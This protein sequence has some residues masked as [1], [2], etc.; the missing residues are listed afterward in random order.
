MLEPCLNEALT[1]AA[2]HAKPQKVSVTI[3]A[4]ANL[5]R[6]CVEN[7]GFIKAIS[8]MG[9]GLRNLR[10]RAAAVGGSV[11]IDAGETFKLICVIPLKE[12]FLKGEAPI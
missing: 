4:T 1:N 9:A 3:D 7:D 8:K 6:L 11:T 12:A 2:R 5:I 10:H